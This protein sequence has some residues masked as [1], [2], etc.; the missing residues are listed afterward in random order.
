MLWIWKAERGDA[1]GDGEEVKV[2][3]RVALSV[4]VVRKKERYRTVRLD[5]D[6]HACYER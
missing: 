5:L 2:D 4:E 1:A 6:R 3:M